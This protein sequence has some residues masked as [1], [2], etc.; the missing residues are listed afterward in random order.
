MAVSEFNSRR[1]VAE[2]VKHAGAFKE[3][4]TVDELQR[5]RRGN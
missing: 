1:R 5:S 3:I 4:M 2:L